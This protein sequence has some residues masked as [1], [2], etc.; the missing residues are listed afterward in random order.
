MAGIIDLC[1]RVADDCVRDRTE[2]VLHN[3]RQIYGIDMQM[4]GMVIA[5]TR[6]NPAIGGGLNGFDAE[7]ARQMR[8][9]SAVLPITGGIAVV[10]DNTW[11]AF[12][13]AQAVECDW[14]VAL[15]R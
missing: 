5:T 2:P 10:A 8:G 14:P 1:R 12:Q 6:T 11:R 7:A 15:Y 9:V 4:D 3:G 13:A